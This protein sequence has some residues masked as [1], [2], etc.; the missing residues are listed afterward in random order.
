M[1]NVLS[2]YKSIQ[3]G[4]ISIRSFL[5]ETKGETQVLIDEHFKEENKIK[6]LLIRVP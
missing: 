4:I 3:R 1:M 2:R 6:A 5:K